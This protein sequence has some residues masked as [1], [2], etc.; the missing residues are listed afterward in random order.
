MARTVYQSC[1]KCLEDVEGE[2]SIDEL[3]SL[4]MREIGGQQN[5]ILQALHVMDS[6]GLIEDIGNNR[7]KVTGSVKCKQ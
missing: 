6:T 2:M 1:V 7:I 3:K 5:T 4:I